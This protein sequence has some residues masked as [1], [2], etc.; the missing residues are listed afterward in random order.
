M[1]SAT[2]WIVVPGGNLGNSSAF[3][4]AF[5]ELHQLGLIDHIPRAAVSTPPG[6]IRFMNFTSTAVCAGTAA[7][8]IRYIVSRLLRRN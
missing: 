7:N 1:V 3:G 2:D 4:K 5:H 6:A 8:R